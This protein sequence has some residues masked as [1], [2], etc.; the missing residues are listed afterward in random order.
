MS[1]DEKRLSFTCQAIVHTDLDEEM[2]I[3]ALLY[4]N[5]LID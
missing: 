1:P 2:Q 3:L 4:L 5:P